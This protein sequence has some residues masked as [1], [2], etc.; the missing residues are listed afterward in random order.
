MSAVP[1]IISLAKELAKLDAKTLEE[2][3][4]DRTTASYKL[5]HGLS[6]TIEERT[7]MTLARSP[8]SLN[9]DESTS[10]SH[11]HVLAILA[12]Y[13]DESS[14][15]VVITHLN[16]S[17]VTKCDANSIYNVI[18]SYVDD[19]HIP[20][21][22]LISV[23]LDSCATM[24][25][26]KTG[27]ETRLRAHV[28]HLVDIDGDICHHIHNTTKVYCKPFN[29]WAE[30]MFFAVHTD[31]TQQSQFGKDLAEVCELI[32]LKYTVPQRHLP[33]R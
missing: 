20:W 17:E 4:M 10:S 19:K 29:S 11:K 8:F 7:V 15:R 23:L 2:V 28:P 3:G 30:K 21:D 24:R 27:V 13:Y 18:K 22:N 14:S 9:I 25:G 6:L 33:H 12:S 32:G 31:A 16:S 1:T 26:K 5:V